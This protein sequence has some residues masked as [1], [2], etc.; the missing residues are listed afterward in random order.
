MEQNSDLLSRDPAVSHLMHHSHHIAP[1]LR[2]SILF[3]GNSNRENEKMHEAHF[4]P[5]DFGKAKNLRPVKSMESATEAPCIKRDD[6]KWAC[7]PDAYWIGCS[8]SGTSSIAHYLNQHPMITNI[9]G[10]KRAEATHSKEGHFW[11]VS[12]HLFKNSKEMIDTRITA[13]RLAQ[14]GFNSTTLRPVLIEF[15]PVIFQNF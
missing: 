4:F 7:L 14:N 1:I 5:E 13:M 2:D 9:V 12:E 15:T 10:S 6:G 11:E 3:D 8:K